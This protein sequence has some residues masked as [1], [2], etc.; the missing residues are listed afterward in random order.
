MQTVGRSLFD[1]ARVFRAVKKETVI[2][3][4]APVVGF[5][6]LYE[7]SNHGRVLSLCAGRWRTKMMRK[8]VPDK[9][10]YATVN[11]K[12][13]GRYKCAKIHRLVAEAFIPNPDKLPAVNHRDENKTNNLVNNLEWCDIKY[14]NNYGS[15]PSKSFKKVIMFDDA[16]NEVQRFN[17]VNSAARHLGVKPSTISGALHGRRSKAAGYKWQIIKEVV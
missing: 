7:V 14:N 17:S 2:E 5:E 12:K 16:G 11:L 15:K 1:Y 4:W 8:P 10:G 9:D 3:K 13:D 6:G